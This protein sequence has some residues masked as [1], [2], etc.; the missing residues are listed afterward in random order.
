[1]KL[2]TY[3]QET[4]AELKHVVWPSRNQAIAVTAAVIIIS[5]LTAAYLGVLDGIFHAVAAKLLGV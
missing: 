3:F 2:T 4:R 1:M 5:I